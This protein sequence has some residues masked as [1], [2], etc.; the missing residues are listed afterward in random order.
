MMESSQGALSHQYHHR[1]HQQH[2]NA[3]QTIESN[4]SIEMTT[5][6]Y[7]DQ[8]SPRHNDYAS[9]NN[10]DSSNSNSNNN[11]TPNTP[12]TKPV[13]FTELSYGMASYYVIILP[14]TFTMIL[15][16]L[17]VTFIQS[18]SIDT[19]SQIN[20]QYNVFQ[21]NDDYSLGTNLGLSLVNALVMV[22][23][24]GAATFLLVLFYK[25]RYVLC[26]I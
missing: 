14:V 21:V 16:A 1:Q 3:I 5:T 23:V 22:C 25:Y 20:R 9:S 2:S 26:T 13:S 15:S 24:V 18:P 8:T 17:T 11:R 10:A 6:S 4:D 12:S 19:S 7:Y